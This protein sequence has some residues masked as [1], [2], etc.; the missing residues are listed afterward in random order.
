MNKK[1]KLVILITGILLI[2][3]IAIGFF[4]KKTDTN[5]NPSNIEITLR[6]LFPFGQKTNDNPTPLPPTNDV[7]P[8]GSVPENLNQ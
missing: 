3:F 5:P 8:P 7:I 1:F 4:L 2:A 6:N